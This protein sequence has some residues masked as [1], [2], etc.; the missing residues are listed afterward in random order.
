MTTITWSAYTSG[1]TYTVAATVSLLA[2]RLPLSTQSNITT[3]L[4]AVA[5]SSLYEFVELTASDESNTL[6]FTATAGATVHVD[7]A[8]A[9]SRITATVTDTTDA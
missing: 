2:L 3:G 5:A 9:T 8:S 1:E 7:A 6:T 4:V